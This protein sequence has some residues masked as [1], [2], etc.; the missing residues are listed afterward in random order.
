MN[1]V[2][3]NKTMIISNV[4]VNKLPNNN[5]YYDKDET[6][7]SNILNIAILILDRNF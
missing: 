5:I 7:M 4:K 1:V 2:K 3:G 6:R